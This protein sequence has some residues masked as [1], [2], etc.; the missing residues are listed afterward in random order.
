VDLVSRLKN[1]SSTYRHG[2]R[3]RGPVLPFF[4]VIPSGARIFSRAE[5]RDQRGAILRQLRSSIRLSPLRRVCHLA[6]PSRA[7]SALRVNSDSS[8]SLP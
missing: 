3:L 7:R 1:R 5:S 4:A 2:L 8:R 6:S